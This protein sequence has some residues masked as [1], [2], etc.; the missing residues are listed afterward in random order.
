MSGLES[1]LPHLGGVRLAE[2]GEMRIVVPGPGNTRRRTLETYFASND[3]RVERLAELDSMLGTLDLVATTPW[4]TVVPGIMMASETMRR[5]F[6]VSRLA[7]PSLPLDLALIE[8]VRRSLAAPA[9]A[10][11]RVLEEEAARLNRVWDEA[12]A[13]A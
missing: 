8:P 13:P 5:Q 10:F 11:L 2:L 1:G 3:V 12:V 4:V 6:T 9:S 7:D